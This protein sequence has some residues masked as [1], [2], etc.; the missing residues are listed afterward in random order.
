MQVK[1]EIVVILDELDEAKERE[2]GGASS[3][4]EHAD[5]HTVSEA[6]LARN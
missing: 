1:D 6:R 5:N 4:D 2:R 3:K